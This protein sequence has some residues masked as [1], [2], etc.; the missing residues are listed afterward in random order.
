VAKIEWRS[1]D[2]TKIP[3][4]I[5]KQDGQSALFEVSG[6]QIRFAISVEITYCREPGLTGAQGNFTSSKASLSIR[7]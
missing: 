6:D 1:S 3:S 4:T 7:Q 5:S 2:L